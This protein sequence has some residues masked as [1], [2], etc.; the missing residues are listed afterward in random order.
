M[1]AGRWRTTPSAWYQRRRDAPPHGG[2]PPMTQSAARSVR[3][4][5]AVVVKD[6]ADILGVSPVEVIKELMKSGVM[7]TINQVIDFDSAAVV[8]TDLGFNAEEENPLAVPAPPA[9]AA[10]DEAPVATSVRVIEE[11]DDLVTRPPVVT[12]LGHVDHGKTTL[13]DTIRKARV[14]AGEAGG[15]TQHVGAYQATAPDG[16]PITFIDTPGHEAFSQMRARGA[17]VTDVAIVVVAANDGVMPQTREAIDHVRAAGVPLVIA[18]NKMDAENANPDRV[19]TQLT[20]VGLVPEEFGGDTVVVPIS[21]LKGD[22]IGELLENVQLVADLQ[23]LKANPNRDAVGVVI[24]SG[25]DRQRGVVATVLVQT[26]TLHV[27]EVILA[28]LAYGKIKAME[29]AAGTRLQQAGPSAA[30]VVLGLSEVPPA[31]ERFT[32]F[33]TEREARREADQRRRDAEAGVAQRAAV[34]LDSLFGEISRGAVQAFNIVL[35]VDVQGSL[36]PVARTLEDL[37]VDE[38]NVRVIHASVGSVNESDVQLASASKGV[39]I[40]FNTDPEPGAVRLAEGEGVEIRQYKI[41]YDV[42]EDVE[43]AVK[44]LLKPIYEEREDGRIEVRQVF[45]LGRRAAI[46]GSYVRDGAI[47]RNSLIR[48]LRRGQV[49]HESRIGSL[50]RF[51]DDVREVTAG[52]E[53]GIQVDGFQ[54]FEE[55]DELIAYHMEQMR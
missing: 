20:E 13:L 9:G 48:I 40:A 52:F 25:T 6:L 21:A 28:G 32:T 1:I 4:P 17:Q 18:M 36:E 23:D 49:I 16:R 22:G 53:C 29:D 35:K 3:I 51:N 43:N 41:I 2:T 45:R 42:V 30:A 34:T 55:G 38:V 44:G 5:Q 27:G 8:A 12:V 50:K 46:A 33:K 7:A 10:E 37:S 19:K 47:N 11:G 39:I 14:A 24:E 26:G 15:I 54:D 31:G